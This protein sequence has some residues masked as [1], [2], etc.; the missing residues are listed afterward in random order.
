MPFVFLIIG[1]VFIIAGVRNTTGD[2]VKLFQ[3]DIQGSNNFVYW[4]LAILAIGS[5]GYVQDLRQL[6]RAF[7]VLVLL[8][9]VL[10]EDKSS[11]A[12]GFFTKFNQA[13]SSITGS[14][15]Q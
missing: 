15:T 2:L 10:A 3:T 8:V 9:L 12:G 6:S 7:L 1:T 11:T 13:I 4:I 14:S 5:L